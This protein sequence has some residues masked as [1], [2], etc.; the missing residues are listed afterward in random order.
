MALNKVI[1]VDGETVITAE[2]LNNIQDAIIELEQGGT[3]TVD[4][5]L[6]STSE[7]P[8]QNKVIDQA[9]GAKAPLASPTFTGTPKAP[10]AAS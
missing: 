5:A 7:N 8:V 4:S 1:Y 2:N 6:S 10:T 9:L 3:I